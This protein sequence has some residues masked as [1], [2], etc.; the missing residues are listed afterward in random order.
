MRAFKGL[1]VDRHVVVYREA[2]RLS[3]DRQLRDFRDRVRGAA[4]EERAQMKLQLPP[5]NGTRARLRIRCSL[6][7]EA[8][9]FSDSI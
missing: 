8:N 4:P 1:G 3:I 2:D 5:M 7:L 9:S 6:T